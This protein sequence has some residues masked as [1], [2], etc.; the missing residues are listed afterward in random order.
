EISGRDLADLSFVDLPGLIASVG[1]G[2]NVQDIELV[3]DLV[4]SYIEKP[5][6]LILL[7]VACETDFEN[8][9]AHHLAKQFDPEGKRTVGVL[10]KPDR[11]PRGEEESWARL[12]RNEREPL[13][14]NWYCVKQPSSDMLKKGVKWGEARRLEEEFFNRTP[15]W[16]NLNS[17]HKTFLGTGNLTERLSII[18]AELIAKRLP[19]IQKD[20]YKTLQQ[21]E[22]EISDL[23]PDPSSNP[24]GEV[25]KVIDEFKKELSERIEGT[26]GEDGILQNIRPHT[27]KFRR[28]IRATAPKFVPWERNNAHRYPSLQATFLSNEEESNI[29]AFQDDDDDDD[30]GDDNSHDSISEHPSPAE[31]RGP[32]AAVAGR[33]PRYIS[34]RV[35]SNI[36][37]V[38]RY[39]FHG[40]TEV[41]YMPAQAETTLPTNAICVD[42]VLQRAEMP[43]QS[44][45]RELPDHYPFVVQKMY[46]S[47]F[48]QNWQR[49][50]FRL[51]DA[52]YRIM[53]KDIEKI[54]N[55]HFA[56]MGRGGAKQSVLMIMQQ[57]LDE[58][59]TRSRDRIDWL[60]QLESSPATSNT[61][62]YFDY[63]N[64]FLA[65]YRAYRHNKNAA[66]KIWTYNQRGVSEVVSALAAIG[67]HVQPVDFPKLLPSDPMDPALNI[68]ASVRAYFQ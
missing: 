46:I 57:H 38:E 68:M 32:Q 6:C 47:E 11:I 25:L 23:P 27:D 16:R 28:R 29:E 5:S 42:E 49:P 52:V 37:E 59:A 24:L 39:P 15:P 34:E 31:E 56:R 1:Q 63:K 8:Q 10:T 9:G 50:A 33:S 51:F 58:A 13:A 22:K 44:R 20:L 48:V 36:E 35:V 66:E 30:S 54:V 17:L 43:V 14:N 18:L 53:K 19:E 2:G 61:H 60:L 4:I 65:F 67:I 3:K 7:T 12:I 41:P 45:T 21:T 40:G 64:K 55:G 26:P 62:Y